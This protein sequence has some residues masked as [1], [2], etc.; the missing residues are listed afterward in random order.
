MNTNVW[1]F[2]RF[3]NTGTELV[4]NIQY[5]YIQAESCTVLKYYI[6][7]YIY[8]YIYI[9]YGFDA[10]VQASNLGMK[11]ARPVWLLILQCFSGHQG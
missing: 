6:I 5:R 2:R 1:I 8:I 3:V 4:R 7:I 11:R 9:I 10:Q